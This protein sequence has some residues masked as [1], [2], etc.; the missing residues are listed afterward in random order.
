MRERFD[1]FTAA[2]RGKFFAMLAK[3]GCLRDSARAAGISK[4]TVRR[5]RAKEAAFDQEFRR[6]LDVAAGGLE[7][8][9][10]ERATV[11][12]EE[13][14]WRGGKLWQVRVK[15]SD[16]ILRLLL[17]AANPKK[18]GRL[19]RGGETKKQIE[20]RLRKE[21]AGELR[22]QM[23]LPSPEEVR[24]RILRKVAAIRRHRERLEPPEGESEGG[25]A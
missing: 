19:S 20:K 10:W 11:G 24:E 16:A 8:T 6:C 12:V 4:E 17:Q 14:I 15:P 5:W 2:K 9:A 21:I 25:G 13:K 22:E 1:G 3:T 7:R 23:R 18:Y